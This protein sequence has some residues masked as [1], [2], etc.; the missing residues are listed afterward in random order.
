MNHRHSILVT[1]LLLSFLHLS[2]SD[3]LLAKEKKLN[4]N[5]NL[6][7][8]LPDVLA[9]E[10]RLRQVLTNIISN[11]IKYTKTGGLTISHELK[12][13]NLITN[14]RDTGIGIPDSERG[15]L[16]QKF[17][18]IRVPETA[19]ISGTGLG[20]WL[21]KQFIEKMGGKIYLES[22]ANTGTQI[23]VELPIAKSAV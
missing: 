11:A 7:L 19:S 20:L 12:G 1:I 2:L 6:K 9:D 5:Y 15:N 16:F 10:R 14:F 22:I 3:P 21:I 18:R 23:T 4:L 17:Y 8:A 13:K